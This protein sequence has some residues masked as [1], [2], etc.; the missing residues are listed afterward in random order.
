MSAPGNAAMDEDLHAFVH[1]VQGCLQVIGLG[2]ELLKG[3]RDDD[4]KFAEIC[5]RIEL[6]RHEAVRLLT[7]Y[8]RATQETK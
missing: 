2:T 8:L 1:D 4:A 7:E 6:E 5:A 3:V